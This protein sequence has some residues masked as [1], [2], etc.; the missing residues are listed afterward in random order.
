MCRPPHLEA[1]SWQINATLLQASTYLHFFS[2]TFHSY[3][4][5][6]TTGFQW[7]SSYFQC[8]QCINFFEQL[9]K[10][11]HPFHHHLAPWMLPDLSTFLPRVYHNGGATKVRSVQRWFGISSL[12]RCSVP[13]F[14]SVPTKKGFPCE[15]QQSGVWCG[16]S[17]QF[18]LLIFLEKNDL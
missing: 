10:R 6:L 13:S 16:M 17:L 18:V 1:H 9:E 12:F 3:N 11:K 8:F 2:L 7:K 4:F 15:S 14:R 5:T